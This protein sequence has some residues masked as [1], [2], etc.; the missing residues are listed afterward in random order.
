MTKKALLLAGALIAMT[1]GCAC[2]QTKP[3]PRGVVAATDGLQLTSAAYCT[4]SPCLERV[5]VDDTQVP[6]RVKVDPDVMVVK[7][8]H[9]LKILWKLDASG[10]AFKDDKA[11]TFKDEDK[12][13]LANKEFAARLSVHSSDQFAGKKRISATEFEIL[14]KNSKDGAWLYNIVVEK[15]GRKCTIDPPIVNE[16]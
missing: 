7:T 1:A 8:N 11:I 6:C 9:N 16:M 10:Y 12:A 14:D 5:T 15:D 13:L 2:A 4:Q 3:G